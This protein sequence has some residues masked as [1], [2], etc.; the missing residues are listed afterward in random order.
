MLTREPSFSRA[1]TIGLRLVDAA[2]DAR[3]RCAGRRWPDAPASRKRTSDS[4]DLAA[5]FDEDLVRPVD[6][7][8]G[9]RVVLE[10]RLE[11]A[12]ARACR[13]PVRSASCALLAAVELDA[14][15]GGDLGDQPLDSSGRAA[16]RRHRATAAGSSRARQSVRNSAITADRR[17]LRSRPTVRHD[18][19]VA[20]LAEP[21]AAGPWGSV[22]GG[23]SRR[24]NAVMIAAEQCASR[25]AL[26]RPQRHAGE[27]PP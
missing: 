25:A 5:P 27:R 21:A 13:A 12:E 19:V 9:D 17:T 20:A 2:A 6:H 8:V 22:R 1:S 4:I 26:A 10:Q 14:P 15:L 18:R 11:R 7:D 16:S 3:R 23:R 24:C